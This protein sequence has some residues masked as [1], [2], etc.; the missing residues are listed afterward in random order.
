MRVIFEKRHHH[1]APL[2]FAIVFSA[3]FLALLVGSA[4]IL[5][6]GKNPFEIYCAMIRAG[7]LSN[8]GLTE[9]LVLA[10]P[11]MLAALGIALALEMQLW[12]V[13][14]E[15]QYLMGMFGAGAV[16][17][18]M[19]RLPGAFV[20]VAMSLAAF[21]SGAAWA[22]VPAFL[23]VR[24]HVS[25]IITTLLL[26]HIATFWISHLVYGPWKDPRGY[27]FPNTITFPDS[28]TLPRLPMIAGISPGRLHA[29]IFIALAACVMMWFVLR[30][31]WIG[32]K[33]RLCGESEEAARH[34]GVPIAR[35]AFLTMAFSGGLA[36]LAGF[37]QVAGV[38]HKLHHHLS[39]GYG[40]TAI[41]IAWLSGKNPLWIIA[42]S[43]LIAGLTTGGEQMQV[44]GV[45][46]S[47]VNIIQAA[48][49]FFVL[50]GDFFKNY[51]MRLVF[52]GAKDKN[53]ECGQSESGGGAL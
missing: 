42:N 18:Y 45:P 46:A 2:S 10:T 21:L 14:A 28:A 12:N 40:Y 25:E 51:R 8:F 38:E 13:G 26:N 20:L 30:R 39:L 5:S 16:V 47:V 15:G 6:I 22:A 19:N 27:N 34:G 48:I 7:F 23:R 32:Y 49:L 9:T 53:L 41:I 17:L 24:M 31:T 4:F 33:I 44:S 37:V 35:Y 50:A 1:G 43:I 29:G 11:L 3:I 36:G 52:S